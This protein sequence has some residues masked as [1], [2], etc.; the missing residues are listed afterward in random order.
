MVTSV[1]KSKGAIPKPSKQEHMGAHKSLDSQTKEE[2]NT[3]LKS[4]ELATALGKSYSITMSGHVRGPTIRSKALEIL[5]WTVREVERR[6]EK[7]PREHAWPFIEGE[8]VTDQPLG[9]AFQVLQE[10]YTLKRPQEFKAIVSALLAA[11]R[12]P[13]PELDSETT[14]LLFFAQR[15]PVNIKQL[16]EQLAMGED[17]RPGRLTT[18]KYPLSLQEKVDSIPKIEKKLRRDAKRLS[19]ATAASGRPKGKDN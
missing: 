8:G 18:N 14:A 4:L 19:V 12:E 13:D 2:R 11:M 10:A 7:V 1:M 6:F 3:I 17:W 16:A 9:R 5:G 15:G